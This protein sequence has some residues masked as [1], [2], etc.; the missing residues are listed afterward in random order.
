MSFFNEY[1]DG[2]VNVIAFNISEKYV[3][4]ASNDRDYIKMI[5]KTD[6]YVAR[7]FFANKVIIVEGDTEEIVFK[8][9]IDLIHPDYKKRYYQKFKL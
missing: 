2:S 7:V 9:T 1:K 3:R 8:Q 5:L 4:L 6:D